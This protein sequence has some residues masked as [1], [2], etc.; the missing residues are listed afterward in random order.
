MNSRWSERFGRSGTT[1]WSRRMVGVLAALSVT[2]GLLAACAPQAQGGDEHTS[3]TLTVATK[4]DLATFDPGLANSAHQPVYLQPVYDS[5]V[6]RLPDNTLEPMLATAWEWDESKTILT[7]T[8]R[9]GVTFSDGTPM[10]A[11]AVKI[12][13]LRFRDS[14]GPTAARFAGVT[15]VE[16][17][18]DD[19]VVVTLNAPD[20][21]ILDYLGNQASFIGSPAAIDAGTIGTEPVGSGPYVLDADKTV[22]GSQYTYVKREGYWDPELQVYDTIVLKPIP[23][24]TARLSA[25][26]SGQVD[27]GTIEPIQLDQAKGAGLSVYENDVN[28]AGLIIFDRDGTMVPALADVRVRQAI[29]YALD[30]DALIEQI[31]KGLAK[32]TSQIFAEE[33]SAFDPSLDD[34]YGLDVEKAKKLM[35]DAGYADGFSV[36]MPDPSATF[37]PAL[38][39]VIGQQLADIGIA[40]NWDSGTT[41]DY[42]PNVISGKYPMA[43]FTLNQ[44]GIPWQDITVALA[45]DATFN[46]LGTTTPEVAELSKTIQTEPDEADEAARTLNRYVTEQAWFA[47]YARISTLFVSRPDTTLEVQR[48]QVV[49]SIYYYRPAS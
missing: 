11:D 28:W 16:A 26:I 23:D 18:S 34:A 45:P 33:S 44:S 22:P 2:A 6:R 5:L 38:T 1:R 31:H 4:I 29:N 9:H 25:I 35:A 21:A 32:P 15:A 27:A 7:F 39:A 47:P 42:I 10:N 8:L 19:T 48:F 30:R 43:Y 17:P 41:A 36:T 37:N 40:V 14:N 12:N 3:R 20:P 46:P 49:P 13:L 24:M